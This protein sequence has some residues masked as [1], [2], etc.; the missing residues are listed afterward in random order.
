MPQVFDNRKVGLSHL[1]M[2]ETYLAQ[3][4]LPKD[5]LVARSARDCLAELG[6][7]EVDAEEDLLVGIALIKALANWRAM[8]QMDREFDHDLHQAQMKVEIQKISK[9]LNRQYRTKFFL[10]ER[11]KRSHQEYIKRLLPHS[12][13]Q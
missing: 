12:Y 2:L 8:T 6:K 10:R 9:F 5:G 3:C 11:P 7:L 4:D 13:I 1:L